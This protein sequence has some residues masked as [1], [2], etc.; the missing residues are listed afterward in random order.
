MVKAMKQK[1]VR[2][3]IAYLRLNEITVSLG[4]EEVSVNSAK[5]HQ[6]LVSTHFLDFAVLEH[7]DFAC[8]NCAA[9]SMRNKYA[10]F[11]F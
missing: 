11:S 1:C 8:G 10:D 9:Q 7:Y 5:G 3:N 2:K 4:G 6:L